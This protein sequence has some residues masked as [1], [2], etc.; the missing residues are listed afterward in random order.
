MFGLYQIKNDLYFNNITNKT[1]Y[2]EINTLVLNITNSNINSFNLSSND[3]Y[4]SYKFMADTS[5]QSFVFIANGVST[6]NSQC[7]TEIEWSYI[8]NN[9]LDTNDES[10]LCT[11]PIWDM[12]RTCNP[13]HFVYD[14]VNSSLSW[15]EA[16]TYCIDKYGTQLFCPNDE[17]TQDELS[18]LDIFL[19]YLMNRDGIPRCFLE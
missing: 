6:P 19:Q 9:C 5:T 2:G 12:S 10:P 17:F 14:L 7:F 1:E 4:I 13:F 16:N 8:L 18:K 11:E 15:N 3:N